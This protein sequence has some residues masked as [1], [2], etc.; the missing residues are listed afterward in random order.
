[1]ENDHE[2]IIAQGH[3]DLHHER[4]QLNLHHEIP[5]ADN[6]DNHLHENC[7]ILLK[8]QEESHRKEIE[9]LLNQIF[10]LKEQLQ[11]DKCAW[12]LFNVLRENGDTI[13]VAERETNLISQGMKDLYER[14]EAV[15]LHL[16]SI[17]KDFCQKLDDFQSGIEK[18]QVQFT[19]PSPCFNS[20]HSNIGDFMGSRTS[21]LELA[22]KLEDAERRLK[23]AVSIFSF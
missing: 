13:I 23:E 14:S 21:E 20:S 1:M 9:K 2:D 19:L 6:D 17:A 15:Y 22:Q 16:S 8:D 3:H 10:E 11:V 5:Y 12:S 7:H 4:Q 18:R